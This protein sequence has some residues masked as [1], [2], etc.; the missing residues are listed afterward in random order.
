MAHTPYRVKA[1]NDSHIKQVLAANGQQVQVLGKIDIDISIGDHIFTQTFHVLDRLHHTLI[2]GVDFMKKHHAFLNFSECTLELKSNSQVVI[3]SI[4]LKT[5]L[6]RTK[7]AVNIPSNSE[8]LITVSVSKQA[9][10]STILLEPIEAK[11]QLPEGLVIAKCLVKV[12]KGKAVIRVLN[13]TNSDVK[14]RAHKVVAKIS[15][16]Q[17]EQIYSLDDTGPS[18]SKT[19]N[20]S[21]SSPSA[22]SSDLSFDFKNSCLSPEEKQKLLAFLQRN[23]SVFATSMDQLGC[24]P[25]YQHHIETIPGAKPIRSAPY[26]QAPKV[27]AEKK[28]DR[29]IAE[30]QKLGIVEPSTSNWASPVVMCFK[31][32]GE[33]RMA[34]DYRKLNAVTVPQSFPLPHLDSVFDAI[35]EAKAQYF[36]CVDLKSGFHQVPLSDESKHKSSFITQSGIYQFTR[37]PFGLM[38]SP[39]TFQAMMSHVLRGLNWKFLLVYVD[40][41]LVF[42]RTFE[43]HLSHLSQDFDRLHEANFAVQELKFLGYIISREGVKVDHEKTEATMSQSLKLKNSYIQYWVW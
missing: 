18:S 14:I 37:M 31:K 23:K 1:L 20:H 2:L 33:M 39:I 29:Q 32:S 21:S 35:G 12:H 6:A 40:D 38:N 41:I 22:S 24:T 11:C 15:S 3:G 25:F 34:I 5:G 10:N 30:F 17:T 27:R 7:K 36:S 42:S 19:Q 43:E 9:D 26:R 13:P 16:V 28:Q 8:T 4:T